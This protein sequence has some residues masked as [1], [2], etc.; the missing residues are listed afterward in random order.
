MKVDNKERV[1]IFLSGRRHSSWYDL[2]C[3][4]NLPVGEIKEI[5]K[6]L[7][8]DGLIREVPNVRSTIEL[9]TLTFAG[10]EYLNRK[11]SQELQRK[12]TRFNK[13]LAFTSIILAFTSLLNFFSKDFSKLI[14]SNGKINPMGV[15]ITFIF[16]AIFMVVTFL[17][18]EELLSITSKKNS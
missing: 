6:E 17:I 14:E 13:I 7:S 9:I 3:K 18:V 16:S 15:L 11:E 5:I 8:I 4:L 10:R 2:S 12:Q 1:L